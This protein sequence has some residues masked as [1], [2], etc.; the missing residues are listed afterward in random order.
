[1]K[2]PFDAQTHHELIRN[3]LESERFGRGS[4]ATLAEHLGLKA[5]FISTALSGKQDFSLEHGIPIAEFLGLKDLEREFLLLLIQRDRAGTKPLKSHFQEKIDKLLNRASR[6]PARIKRVNKSLAPEDV[7]RYYENWTL[8]VIHMALLNPKIRDQNDLSNLL[9]IDPK[10]VREGLRLLDELGFI[11]RKNDGWSVTQN[12]I[13]LGSDSFPLINHHRNFRIE[14]MRSMEKKDP[15]DLHYTAVI[16]LDKNAAAKLRELLVET[17]S[18]CDP[19]ISDAKDTQV[20]IINIDLFK[21]GKT[22]E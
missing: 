20:Q 5:S 15:N 17:I 13:H 19:I 16:S 10:Q 2:K 12:S 21:V 7:R 8:S 4:Q 14:A 6:T 22:L 18:N 3:E 1:M 9:G 11:Q